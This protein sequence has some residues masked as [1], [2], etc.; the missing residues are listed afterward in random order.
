MATETWLPMIDKLRCTGS[1]DCVAI[2]PTGALAM[3][4][5]MAVV[6]RPDACT[7]CVRCESVCPEGA[8]SLPYQIVLER[9]ALLL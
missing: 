2:C 3:V 1:G 9:E 5:R 6:V 8:V 7:Y 4:G